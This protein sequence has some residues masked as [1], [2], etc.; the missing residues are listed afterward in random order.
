VSLWGGIELRCLMWKNDNCDPPARPGGNRR[1][2]VLRDIVNGIMYVLG[3]GCQW[4]AV[5]SD[6]PPCSPLFDY[7]QRWARDPPS[8]G[9]TTRCTSNVV[10]RQAE[11]RPHRRP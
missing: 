9:C 7:L 8:S 2:V 4:R 5:P 11:A 1:T 6:L 10:R 3:T